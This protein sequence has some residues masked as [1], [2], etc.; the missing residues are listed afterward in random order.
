MTRKYS[1]SSASMTPAALTKYTVLWDE[2]YAMKLKF[3]KF[4]SPPLS[5]EHKS[6]LTHARVKTLVAVDKSGAIV[7]KPYTSPV[8]N[9]QYDAMFLVY[10]EVA[11]YTGRG[12]DIITDGIKYK[13]N[14][15]T[16]KSHVF[17]PNPKLANVKL[18]TADKHKLD[19]A[20]ALWETEGDWVHPVRSSMSSHSA[21]SYAK[22]SLQSGQSGSNSKRGHTH[23][24]STI[25]TIKRRLHGTSYRMGP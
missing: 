20:I 15:H 1:S 19:E 12:L 24:L 6:R 9:P 11:G 17:M 14:Y 21:A 18:T 22:A 5:T 10:V 7:G 13:Y 3:R 25:S 4:K 8:T 2:I 16:A 23:P